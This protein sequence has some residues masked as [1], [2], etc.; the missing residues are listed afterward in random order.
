MTSGKGGGWIQ[1]IAMTM[2]RTTNLPNTQNAKVTSIVA[3]SA[4][5]RA[6]I[7]NLIRAATLDAA[8]RKQM[9]ALLGAAVSL[10]QAVLKVAV[11]AAV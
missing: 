9:A 8:E 10:T 6:Q 2:P 5:D 11:L 3:I 7:A 4:A 1:L